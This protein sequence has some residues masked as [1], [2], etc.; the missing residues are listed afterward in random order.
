MSTLQSYI[1]G[2]WVGERAAKPLASA[3][4]GRVVAHTHEESLDFAEAIGFAR[5]TALPGDRKSVV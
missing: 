4:N 1:A 2:R 5:G 3:I